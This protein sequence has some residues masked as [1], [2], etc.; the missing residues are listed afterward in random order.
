MGSVGGKK[1]GRCSKG[2]L[3][4]LFPGQV[5]NVYIRVLYIALSS[6]LFMSG[7]AQRRASSIL[8]FCQCDLSSS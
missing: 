7:G 1:A 2:S 5:S 6:P 4:R 8:S 3:Q